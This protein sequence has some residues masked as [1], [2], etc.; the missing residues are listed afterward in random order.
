MNHSNLNKIYLNYKI[1]ILPSSFEGNPKVVLEAMS[2]GAL[3]IAKDNKNTSEII[4]NGFNG[5]I[6]SKR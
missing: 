1:F 3:V 4:K 5:V 6:I 2:R